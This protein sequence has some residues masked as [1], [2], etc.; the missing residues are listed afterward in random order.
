MKQLGRRS[1][2]ILN[3]AWVE[4]LFWDGRS[5]DL[6][7]QALGPIESRDEMNQS[8]EE[9][10]AKLQRHRRLSAPLRHGLSR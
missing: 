5:A 1:P 8:L 10:L 2:T 7:A 4:P 3:L 6:E 9:V